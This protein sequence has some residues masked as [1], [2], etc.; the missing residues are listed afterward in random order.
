MVSFEIRKEMLCL[1]SWQG[2]V[3]T[4]GELG[5]WCFD[6]WRFV[7]LLSSFANEMCFSQ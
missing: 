3:G 1:L 2:R 5:M 6:R 4:T 7:V